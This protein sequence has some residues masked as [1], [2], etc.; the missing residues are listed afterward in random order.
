MRTAGEV[1][2]CSVNWGRCGW[3]YSTFKAFPQGLR[4]VEGANPYRQNPTFIRFPSRTARHITNPKGSISRISQKFHI[5]PE[6]LYHERIAFHIT[7]ATAARWMRCAKRYTQIT[8]TLSGAEQRGAQSNGSR[9][10]GEVR[11]WFRFS[12]P[13]ETPTQASP[14]RG[15]TT[16]VALRSG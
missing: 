8:V 5:T 15:S 13:G 11:R 1:G 4:V 9:R 14:L 10:L 16:G 12:A 2:P 7:A 6:G 3:G